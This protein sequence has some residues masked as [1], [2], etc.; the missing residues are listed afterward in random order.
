M[1]N[2]IAHAKNE[3][4]NIGEKVKCK[5]MIKMALINNNTPRNIKKPQFSIDG[6]FDTFWVT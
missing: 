2:I 3:N 5:R 6:R 1:P 4:S